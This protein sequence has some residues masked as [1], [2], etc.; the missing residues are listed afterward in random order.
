MFHTLDRHQRIR[1]L[2]HL[3]SLAFHD[4]HFEAVVVV[5]MDVHAG[6][7]LPLI[8]MLN[9]G[10]FSGQITHMMVV[11]KGDRADSLLVLIPLLPN[12]IIS[13]QVAERF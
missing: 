13:N 8:V 3:R 9:V 6:K 7:Y 1:H 2:A 4:E 12:Q 5:E 10:Q 11:H